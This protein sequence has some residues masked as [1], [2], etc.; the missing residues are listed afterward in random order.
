MGGSLRVR[1][2]LGLPRTFPLFILNVPHSRKYLSPGQTEMAGHI[3]SC[4]F[5]ALMISH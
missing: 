4:Q 1:T 2:P 3:G 5:G